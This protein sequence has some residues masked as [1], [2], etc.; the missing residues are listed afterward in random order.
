MWDSQRW[1]WP[2]IKGWKATLFSSWHKTPRY[3]KDGGLCRAEL[4]TQRSHRS[5][6]KL[7][8]KVRWCVQ[9]DFKEQTFISAELFKT[10]TYK[11]KSKS[12]KK[13]AANNCVFIPL[14]FVFELHIHFKYQIKNML[15]LLDIMCKRSFEKVKPWF[16]SLLLYK[17]IYV[18]VTSVFTLP[19]NKL[20]KV[21][22]SK[23]NFYWNIFKSK[24]IMGHGPNKGEGHT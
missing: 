21:F 19:Q 15:H 18:L 23:T 17:N 16:C 22:F 13:T 3:T 9:D 6:E 12:V 8:H 10:Q 11:I 24:K 7:L 4:P 1:S 2:S 20:L 5:T 14:K